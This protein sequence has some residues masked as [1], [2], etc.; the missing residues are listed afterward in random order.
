MSVPNK[1]SSFDYARPFTSMDHILLDYLNDV[2]E[3]NEL[4]L[5]EFNKGIIDKRVVPYCRKHSKRNS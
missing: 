1:F 3:S 4:N 2:N 5:S